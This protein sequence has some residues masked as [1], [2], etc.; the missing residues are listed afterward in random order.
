[1]RIVQVGTSDL[2]GGAEKTAW[3]LHHAFRERG[4]RSTLVVGTKLSDDPDVVELDNSERGR[5]AGRLKVLLEERLGV[6]YIDFP[7]SHRIP[8]LLGEWDVLHA[9]NLH[10]SYFDLAALPRL[11]RLAPTI[12]TLHDLWLATGHCAHPLVGDGWSWGCGSCP[13]LAVYPSVTRD[14]TRYNLRRKQRLLRDLPLVVSSPAQWLLNAVEETYLATKPKRLVPDPVDTGVFFPAEASAARA[15]LDLPRDRPVVLFPARNLRS[16]FRDPHA[17]VD[18]LR[19][20]SDLRPVGI[21]FG[22]AA[23]ALSGDVDLRVFPTTWDEHRMASFYQAADATVYPSLAETFPV[24]ILESLATGTPIV[25]TRVGGIPEIV[26]D[27]E[28]GFLADR[29]DVEGLT[30]AIRTLLETEH[31]AMRMGERGVEVVRSRYD[32]RSVVDQWL[33]WYGELGEKAKEQTAAQ[34]H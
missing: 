19:R 10:G 18:A 6:Q 11:T 32:L 23:T 31:L 24:A 30:R 20:L 13:D 9:H 7:G 4:H 27:G 21:A 17:F 29:G 12:L 15:V 22:E 25:A 3:K 16:S 8:E 26:E 14:A 34:A 33:E 1:M 2:G 28:T 5:R